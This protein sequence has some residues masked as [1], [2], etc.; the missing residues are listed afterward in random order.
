MF[1][2]R[3]CHLI[4]LVLAWIAVVPNRV[5]AAELKMGLAGTITSVDPYFS[6]SSANTS[7]A[8][9][10]FDRLT[11]RGPDARLRP[12][13]AMSWTPVSE[14]IWEFKLRPEVRFHDGSPL[15]AEDVAFSIA[16]VLDTPG[17]FV[18]LLRAIERV[19]IVDAG[20]VRF[21][22]RTPSPTLPG[23]LSGIAILSHKIA[24]KASAQDYNSG[25]AAI[26]TGPYKFARFIPGDRVEL[27]RNDT[28]WGGKPEW[29]RV[30]I[31]FIPN[32]NARTAAILAGE[33]DVIDLPAAADLPRLKAD[34]RLAVF[35]TAGQRAIFLRP[36]FSRAG[37]EPFLTDLSGKT[38]AKNPLRDLRVRKAL[39]LAINREELT[40]GVMMRT[41]GL[42]GQWLTSEMFGYNPAIRAP[43]YEPNAAKS[44]LIAAGFP[45]GFKSTLHTSNDRSPYDNATAIAIAQMWSRI[46]VQTEVQAM[47]WSVYAPRGARQEWSIGLWD[48]GNDNAEAG[49]ALINLMG[50]YDP[51]QR[52]GAGNYGRYSNP[53]LDKLTD[54]ALATFN[55]SRREGLLQQAVAMAMDDLAIIPLYQLINYWVVRKGLIYSA[56][57]DERTVAMDVHTTR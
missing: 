21:H 1:R 2:L 36:D 38:L 39:S 53:A 28:W 43:F 42:T 30:V 48:W 55:N 25:Q 45:L 46:G 27:I 44:L 22:T 17:G 14:T 15:T 29:D 51:A 31:R 23:D 13:L 37:D 8:M 47:P 6:N 50:T 7:L 52:R 24:D 20:T 11:E 10:L 33:V 54:E 41:A 3:P 5:V 26:G 4:I 19:E 18:P 35:S 49:S 32:A 57:G 16:R 40:S 9:H 34:F 12:G 56:R